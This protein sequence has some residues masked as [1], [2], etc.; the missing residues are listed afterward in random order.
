MMFKLVK[1]RTAWWPVTWTVACEELIDGK[2]HVEEA[3]VEMQFRLLGEESIR[4]LSAYGT[5]I[6]DDHKD[7]SANRRTAMV[8]MR[9]IVDWGEIANDKGVALPFT[10]D[11]LTEFVD[12]P[13]AID[14]IQKAFRACRAGEGTLRSKN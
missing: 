3:R 10:L 2:P 11:A 7:V 4:D 6:D 12:L 9:C 1:E 14:A 5:K 8:L 13:D